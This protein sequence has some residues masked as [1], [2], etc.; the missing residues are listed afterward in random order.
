MEFIPS[1]SVYAKTDCWEKTLSLY[2]KYLGVTSQNSPPLSIQE[3]YKDIVWTHLRQFR[4]LSNKV[5]FYLILLSDDSVQSPI[6]FRPP[7]NP[8]DPFTKRKFSPTAAVEALNALAVGMT[9]HEGISYL[10]TSKTRAFGKIK[11]ST[12][13]TIVPNKEY[14]VFLDFQCQNQK[15]ISDCLKCLGFK[16]TPY[17]LSHTDIQFRQVVLQTVNKNKWVPVNNCFL[18]RSSTGL[19]LAIPI[20]SDLIS[21][22]VK[23]VVDA[24]LH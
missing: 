5:L 15:A 17:L 13:K 20:S 11:Q 1:K 23:K 14:V 10:V 9:V 21:R 18:R 4:T 19:V 2:A 3:D 6:W 24:Y 8:T 12:V 22:D 16:T 7:N